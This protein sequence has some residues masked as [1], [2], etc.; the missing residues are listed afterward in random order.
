MVIFSV[1]E[2]QRVATG[3][4]C[5]TLASPKNVEVATLILEI[6]EVRGPC[7]VISIYLEPICPLFC[8]QNKA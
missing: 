6:W 2:E 1:N 3:W 5:R 8:L 7:V 4:G